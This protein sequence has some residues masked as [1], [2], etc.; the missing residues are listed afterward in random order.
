MSESSRVTGNLTVRAGVPPTPRRRSFPFAS[1]VD[2]EALVTLVVI[3]SNRRY[4]NSSK[5]ITDSG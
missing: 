1:S 3:D 4:A 5:T 2:K